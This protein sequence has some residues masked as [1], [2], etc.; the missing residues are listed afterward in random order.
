MGVAGAE[1]APKWLPPAES[2][3]LASLIKNLVSVRA[4]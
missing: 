2:Q 4:Y 3:L 1:A